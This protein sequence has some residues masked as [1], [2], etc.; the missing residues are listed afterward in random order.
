[1]ASGNYAPYMTRES[2]LKI[3]GA[4]PSRSDSHSRHSYPRFARLVQKVISAIFS[5][6]A[7]R[8]FLKFL[9]QLQATGILECRL[10][11]SIV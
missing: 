8:R 3:Q 11:G 7:A 4:D 5:K 2:S 6:I 9:N 1:M 10:I